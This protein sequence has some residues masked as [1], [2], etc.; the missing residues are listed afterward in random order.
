M[1]KE[2][3]FGLVG[4]GATGRAFLRLLAGKKRELLSRHGLTFRLT[5]I[6]TGSHGCAI[7]RRGRHNDDLGNQL[8]GS[9]LDT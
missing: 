3:T 6:A 1:T 5:G 2:I 7:D 9:R 4:F 8:H